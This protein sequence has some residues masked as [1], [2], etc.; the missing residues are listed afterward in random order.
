[1]AGNPENIKKYQFTSEQSREK[2]AINGQKGGVASGEAKRENKRMLKALEFVLNSPVAKD[3]QL[4]GEQ[5]TQLMLGMHALAEKMKAGDVKAAE[6]IRDLIGEKPDTQI[7]VKDI[8]TV[9]YE[10]KDNSDAS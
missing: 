9:P 6:F 1:M 8:K 2:A 4:F 5:T 3:E 10:Y 7:T